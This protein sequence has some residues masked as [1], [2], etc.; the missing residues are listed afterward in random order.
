MTGQPTACPL[1][2]PSGLGVRSRSVSDDTGPLES[3]TR[4]YTN[5]AMPGF[6]CSGGM[7]ELSGRTIVRGD[8]LFE[9]VFTFDDPNHYGNYHRPTTITE[10]GELSRITTPHTT[11]T[12]TSIPRS[13][14]PGSTASSRRKP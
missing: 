1:N 11:T 8:Q 14:F 2:A 13:R 12:S 7:P 3:D 4:T 10:T 5:V 9:T 6:N